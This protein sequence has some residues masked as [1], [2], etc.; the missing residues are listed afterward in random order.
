MLSDEAKFSDRALSETVLWERIKES[1]F[2]ARKQ[3][4]LYLHAKQ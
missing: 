2:Q 3:R 1:S 4:H